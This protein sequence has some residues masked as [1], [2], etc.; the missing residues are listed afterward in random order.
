MRRTLVPIVA[1]MICSTADAAEL[2]ARIKG[3]VTDGGGA[4]VPGAVVSVTSPSLQG[5][6]AAT[7]DADGRFLIPGLPIGTYD[8]QVSMPGFNSARADDLVLRAGESEVLTFT[9]NPDEAGAE[10]VVTADRPILD[11][12]SVQAGMTLDSAMLKDLPSEGRSY[13]GVTAM[14]PGAVGG[15][16]SNVRGGMDTQDQF[17]VDGV[18]ITDPVT[19]TFSMNMNYDAIEEVQVITGGMDAEYGRALGGA[20]NIVTKSG[21]NEWTGSVYAQ[22]SDQNF[23]VYQPLD[24]IDSPELDDFSDMQYALNVGGPIIKD[25]LWFFGSAQY[26]LS[27]QRS[28]FD[29]SLIGRPTG[30]DPITPWEDEMSEIS[31]REWSSKYLFGKLTYQPNPSHRVWLHAQADPTAI[32]NISQSAYVLPSAERSQLQGGWLGGLGHIWML[33]NQ[34]TLETQLSLTHS[35]IKNHSVLWQ[36]CKDFDDR[37]ACTD[38]WGPAWTAADPGGFDYGHSYGSSLDTRERRSINSALTLYPH[39]MGSHRVKLGVNIEQ[40]STTAVFPGYNDPGLAYYGHTS[41]DDDGNNVGDA[42]NLDSYTPDRLVRYENDGA[43]TLKAFMAS[44]YLQDVWNPTDRLTVRPGVRLDRP[45]LKDDLGETVFQAVAVSP[46][47]GVAYDLSGSGKTVVHGYYGRFADPGFLYISSILQKKSQS[48][49]TYPWSEQDQD[50]ASESTLSTG[51]TFLA[52]DDLDTPTSDAIDLGIRH[53]FNENSLVGATYVRKRSRGFWED[54]EVNLIWNDEGTQVIGGRN[55]RAEPIYRLRTSDDRYIEY[56]SLEMTFTQIFPERGFVGGSYVWSKAYGNNDDQGA[57]YLFD[58]YPQI[59]LE[60]NYLSYDRTHAVKVFGTWGRDAVV[61]LGGVDVGYLSGWNF[62]MYSGT[63]YRPIYWNDYYGGPNNFGEGDNGSLR[64]PTF[65][66][67]DL[68]AGLVIGA[69]PTRLELVGE[70]FNAFNDRTV[71]SV[72][73]TWDT[74]S[75]DIATDAQGNPLFGTPLSYQDPRYFRVSL[76]GQF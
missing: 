44:A 49:G 59:P 45:T 1:L 42:S 17:Y 19:N 54:D 39:W 33:S 18:N 5:T 20:V 51:S 43:S 11:T 53:A 75:G 22:Y 13:Q 52:H 3:T 27:V 40:M 26:D 21:G 74:A 68:K 71:T 28:V 67:T 12:E 60:E 46:R 15:G 76:R 7:T 73:T 38:D 32:H 36:D 34:A 8:V 23:M 57:T 62:R 41:T 64:M 31:P 30:D 25:R 9:I 69:G 58:I 37:G 65:S 50:W 16:N 10:I 14:A 24:G 55:G 35:Y 66:Q 70:V 29:N 61:S 6:Q 63:P 56:D 48:Y 47:F 72:D 2:T 4:P